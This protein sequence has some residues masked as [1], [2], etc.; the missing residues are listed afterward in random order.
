M[1]QPKSF[2]T[3]Q[4]FREWLEKNHDRKTELMMRL[5]KTS[6]KHRGIGYREALDEALCF[7]WIDGVRRSFDEDSFV[8]RF[9]PRRPKSYWSLVNIKR[10]KALIAERRMRPPGLAAFAK[11]DDST[12]PR[13][14]FERKD[15]ELAPEFT[16]AFK[17]NAVAWTYFQSRP[18]WYRRTAARWVMLAKRHETRARRFVHLLQRSAKQTT[19]APLTS[20]K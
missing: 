19:I 13:Y 9:T 17:T 1:T 4:A 12:K 16:R 14:T 10:A 7:G 15:L 11:R 3:R 20:T 8:Q 6:A 2:R 5:F 18:P